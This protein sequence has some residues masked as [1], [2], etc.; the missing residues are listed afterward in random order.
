MNAALTKATALNY[1]RTPMEVILAHVNLAICWEP[2]INHAMV[3]L[4]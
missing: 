2:I 4:V 1:A 3:R